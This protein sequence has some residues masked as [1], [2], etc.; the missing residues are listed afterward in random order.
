MSTLPRAFTWLLQGLLY[1]LFV[2]V[3]ALFSQ[4]PP[5]HH[6]GKDDALLKLSIVHLG[7]RLHAC[8][9]PSAEELAKLPPTMRAPRRC[10]RERAPLAIEIDLDGQPL[11]RQTA[12]PGGLSRDGSASMYER[13]VVAAGQHHIAVRM[14]DSAR[15]EGF[16]H[17]R[18]SSVNLRPAQILVIDFDSAKREITIR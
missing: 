13:R 16:D 14:R 4:W 12:R 15:S 5:Y 10:P 11:L 17:Q 8:V 6:L 7:E 3:L 18:E 1:A 2:G 9:E